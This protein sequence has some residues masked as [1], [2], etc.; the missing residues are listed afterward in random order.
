MVKYRW[1][2]ETGEFFTNGKEYEFGPEDDEYIQ[3][4]DDEG[5][6]HSWSIN[7]MERDGWELVAPLGPIRTEGVTVRRLEPGVYGRLEVMFGVHGLA[8]GLTHQSTN[9]A[10]YGTR[11]TA[12]ELR[13]LA[14]EIA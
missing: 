6:P 5:D 14:L 12:P 3:T 13:E 8:I 7:R 10:S 4:I 11:L 2:D 1:T 9:K